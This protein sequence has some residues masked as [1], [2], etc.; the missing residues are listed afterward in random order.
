MKVTAPAALYLPNCAVGAAACLLASCAASAD[1]PFYFQLPFLPESYE[2]GAAWAVSADGQ[3]VAGDDHTVANPWGEL[4]RWIVTGPGMAEAEALGF[5]PWGPLGVAPVAISAD[6]LV[7]AATARE[8]FGTGQMATR[9]A[10][11]AAGGPGYTALGVLDGPFATDFSFAMDMSDDGSLIVGI[12]ISTGNG[13]FWQPYVWHL[14]DPE[15]GEGEM[16]ALPLLGDDE[17]GGARG[18]TSEGDVIVGWSGEST[19]AVRWVDGVPQALGALEEGGTSTAWAISPNGSYIVGAATLEGVN[20]PFRWTEAEGM[21]VLD[22][23]PHAEVFDARAVAND[24]TAITFGGVG[25]NGTVWTPDGQ[26]H[27]IGA[28]L[29]SEFGLDVGRWESIGVSSISADSRT[30]VGEGSLGVPAE[31][32]WVAFLGAGCPADVNGD[33]NLNVLDFVAF[34]LLWQAQD[35][36]ADCDAN[37]EFNVLDFVCFQQLFVEGCE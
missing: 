3:F 30:F 9:W 26:A 13:S 1:D 22:Q 6:G 32:P 11:P 37:A 36:G 15:T 29:M 27:D 10:D 18:V 17:Q 31:A 25:L 8:D 24:G 12:S 19:I 23:P 35:P 21:H 28:W 16:S 2:T 33:G 4:V 14:I 5:P 20:R 34:Q 7:I